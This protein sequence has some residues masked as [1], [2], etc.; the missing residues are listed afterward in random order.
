[1]TFYDYVIKLARLRQFSACDTHA[2]MKEKSDE[3]ANASHA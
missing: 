2:A 3:F 1:M